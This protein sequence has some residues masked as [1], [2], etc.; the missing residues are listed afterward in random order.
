[1]NPSDYGQI[2]INSVIENFTRFIVSNNKII[3][4][5]DESLD[6]IVNKVRILGSSD[7][8]W[9]DTKISDDC[10]KREIGKTTIYFLDGEIILQKKELNAKSFRKLKQ[11]YNYK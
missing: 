6:N 7:L 2:I 5:I 4:Q 8:T 1:M 11:E 10:F 9:I 3:F